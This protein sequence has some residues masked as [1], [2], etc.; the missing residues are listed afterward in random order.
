MFV[1][2]LVENAVDLRKEVLPATLMQNY[3]FSLRRI[4]QGQITAI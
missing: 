4:T 3:V 1:P 2:I